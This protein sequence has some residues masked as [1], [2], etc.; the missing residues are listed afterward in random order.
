M[1]VSERYRKLRGDKLF[2]YTH[3]NNKE[4]IL[5]SGRIIYPRSIL[6]QIRIN[7]VHITDSNSRN[8]DDCLGYNQYVFFVFTDSHPFIYRQTINKVP[9]VRGTVD[10]SIL[11]RPGVLIADRVATDSSVILYTPEDALEILKIQ[12]CRKMFIK[13]KTVWNEVK[14][15]EILIPGSIDLNEYS[16]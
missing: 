1:S 11:D 5:Q 14:K 13:D 3:E 15:Y 12:F 8:R 2:H 4:L 9:L 10:V 7:P 16:N 6:E